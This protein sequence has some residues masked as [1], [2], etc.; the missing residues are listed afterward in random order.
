MAEYSTGAREEVRAKD[1]F[2]IND[3]FLYIQE[4]LLSPLCLFSSDAIYHSKV[5]VI[6]RVF[7]IVIIHIAQRNRWKGRA[8]TLVGMMIMFSNQ[9]NMVKAYL[10]RPILDSC[11]HSYEFY[12]MV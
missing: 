9:K 6:L 5:L 12:H 8:G 2:I 4:S 10:R 1:I 7:Q 3:A 11:R